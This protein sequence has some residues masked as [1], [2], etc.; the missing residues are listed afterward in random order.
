MLGG[1]ELGASK[2][3]RGVYAAPQ[4][5]GLP[6]ATQ[7]FQVSVIPFLNFALCALKPSVPNLIGHAA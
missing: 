5:I 1:D 3:R 6:G 4:P 2:N 7:N